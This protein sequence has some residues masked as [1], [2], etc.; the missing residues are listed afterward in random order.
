MK[1]YKFC[2]DEATEI[3][4]VLYRNEINK[5]FHVTIKKIF[6]SYDVHIELFDRT[7]KNKELSL[8]EKEFFSQA[9]AIA[10]ELQF[11]ITPSAEFIKLNKPEGFKIKAEEKIKKLSRSYKG[12]HAGKIYNS[13]TRVYGT[14]VLIEKSLLSYSQYGLLFNRC[15]KNITN[16]HASVQRVRF[17]NLMANTIAEIEEGSPIENPA[18]ADSERSFGFSGRISML[19]KEMFEREMLVNDIYFNP[20][21]DHPLLDK[22]EAEI[23]FSKYTGEVLEAN[24]CIVFSFG[25]NYKRVIDYKLKEVS[26]EEI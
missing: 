7:H 17:S 5:L 22:Y 4:G 19:S 12:D 14:E 3:N 15:Y 18:V 8:S 21:E 20:L 6:E 1:F 2:Y 26:H 13:L 10:D 24:L 25:K 11:T 16:E 9:A 23:K